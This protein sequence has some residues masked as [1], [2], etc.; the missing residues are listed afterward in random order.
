MRSLFLDRSVQLT[1]PD[2]DGGQ[3]PSM[4]VILQK[5]LLVSVV[6]V[7]FAVSVSMHLSG[8]TSTCPQSNITHHLHLDVTSKD[9]VVT[10]TPSNTTIQ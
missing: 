6:A 8:T 4:K 1:F 2:Q 3:S 5:S 9:L 7:V 10:M